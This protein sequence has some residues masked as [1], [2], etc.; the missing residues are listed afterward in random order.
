MKAV[1]GVVGV[2]V[3]V[4]V[5]GL[6]AMSANNTLVSLD[7]QVKASW[8]QVENTYQRRMDL[9][10]NLVETVKGVAGFEK[11]T[12]TQVAEARAKAGQIQVSADLL[13]DPQRLEQFEQA[14]RQLS[15]S[16]GRLLATAEAYP[17]LKAN[18]NFRD[19]QAQLEGT[20]NRIAVERRRFNEAVSQYNVAVKRFP[21]RIVA[22]LFGHSPK[23]Y[24]QADAAAREA[25]KVQF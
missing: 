9:I 19:L 8:S 20:E 18:E 24:F 14:Q 13:A 25:P 16:L 5:L 15:T 10:P 12:Y 23:A 4:V 6:W 17:Q 1:I 7:E 11:E 3:A 21:T 2:V 22:G